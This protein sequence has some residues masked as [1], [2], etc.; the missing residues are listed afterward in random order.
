MSVQEFIEG[1]AG[2]VESVPEHADVLALRRLSIKDTDERLRRFLTMTADLCGRS[3][4]EGD[5]LRQSGSTLVRLPSGGRAVGYHA[6]GAMMVSAGLEPLGYVFGP[7]EDNESLTAQ[8]LDIAKGIELEAWVGRGERLEFERLW[9]I[10]ASATDPRETVVDAVTVRAI[11]AFRHF[12]GEV[13]VWGAA[14]ATVKI[15]AGARVDR[16]NIQ[17]RPTSGDVVDSVSVISPEQAARAVAGQLSGLLTGSE[18]HFTDVA[19][20]VA[21]MFGY[22]SHGKRKTQAYLAPAYVAMVQTDGEETFNHLAVVGASEKEYG[23]FCGIASDPGPAESGRQTATWAEQ[24]AAGRTTQKKTEVRARS[25]ESA[26]P[27][28]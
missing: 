24:A 11:G 21:F 4:K 8:L 1:L 27:S 5:W 18:F 3:G 2:M 22:F 15:A 14:S 12:V 26:R 13:P 6:S 25:K 19:K 28:R 20:P 9:Q 23:S 17:I 7:G 16:M 10:K